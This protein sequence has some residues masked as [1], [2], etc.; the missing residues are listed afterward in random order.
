MRQDITAN[1]FGGR[2]QIT[3][4]VDQEK[5]RQY[6]ALADLAVQLRTHSRG[7][8]SAAVLDAMNY[9][10]PLITNANGAMEE[11]P[12]DTVWQLPN[13]FTTKQL[14]DALE[15]LWQDENK[16]KALGQRAKIYLTNA[17]QPCDCAKHYMKTIENCHEMQRS[18]P[19]ALIQRLIKM[20]KRSPTSNEAKDLTLAIAYSFPARLPT[21]QLLIDVTATLRE[22]LKTGIQRAVKSLTKTLI[23]A[24]PSGFRVEPVYLCHNGG[25]WH[26]RYARQWTLATLYSL[27]Q[28]CLDDV[29]IELSTTDQLLILDYNG[30]MAIAAGQSGLYKWLKLQGVT[31]HSVVYDLLPITMPWVFP[32]CQFGY[33]DWLNTMA[34]T[35]DSFFCISHSVTDEL[36]Q[37]L[38]NN[39]P[40]QSVMPALHWFHLGA[41]LENSTPSRGMPTDADQ[42]L[43]MCRENITFLMVGTIE[44]RKGYLQV[45]E[46]FTRLWRQ[47]VDINLVIV[48][49]EGWQK[50][51]SHQRCTI[52]DIV[53]CL[54]C[55]PE[56]SNRL[57]WLEDI[58]DEYLENIY[59][60]S[61]CL[62]A[63]SEG[64]GFGLPLIEAAQHKLPIIARDIPVFREVAGIS[65][66]YFPNDND[67]GILLQTIVDW[68]QLFKTHK[69]PRS[70]TM[71]W[72]T[73]KHSAEQLLDCLSATESHP[74]ENYRE[75]N[76]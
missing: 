14:A 8:T 69:H 74:H 3:D 57:F 19:L 17:H 62:I 35:V 7:E 44:P 16:R 42:L 20:A 15:T 1:K 73:W 47:G 27:E 60:A 61:T 30:P 75:S 50:I 72:L 43:T 38:K 48:G 46:T 39:S 51:P 65:A 26:Y 28:T 59:S 68:L 64:E 40:Q 22:D 36:A 58:S 10:L 37:W 55:H 56:R 41:D 32:P 45:V 9:A 66:Y 29:P 76:I 11:L 5:F 70:D 49:R 13:H 4:W 12:A 53:K 33:T 24:P 18:E 34:V 31:L 52:P 2:V 6:L 25:V 67:P 63:A 21:R 71:P 54:R 23:E